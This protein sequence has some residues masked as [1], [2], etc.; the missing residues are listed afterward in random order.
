LVATRYSPSN[1]I[2]L[3]WSS[4]YQVGR[5]PVGIYPS[6]LRLILTILVPVAFAVTIP[7]EALTGRLSL[8]T[9]T[10]ATA[11]TAVIFTISHAIWRLGLRN[12]AG[13]SA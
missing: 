2:V 8:S 11:L 12:Y 7:S 1:D 4:L 9:L 6:W 3:V 13:A 10:L 5:W